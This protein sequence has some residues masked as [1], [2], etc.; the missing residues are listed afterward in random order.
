MKSRHKAREKVLQILYQLDIT[1]V[2][3]NRSLTIYKEQNPELQ[4]QDSFI[5]E[6]LDVIIQHQPEIDTIIKNT[7]EHWTFDRIAVVDRN[8]LR[9]ALAELLYIDTIPVNATIN[10]AIELA[11]KFSTKD[12]GKFVNGILDKIVKSKNINKNI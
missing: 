5:E 3:L 1:D 8:I 7:V 9:M 12:S 2:Q 11:K 4:E 6:L 10:E